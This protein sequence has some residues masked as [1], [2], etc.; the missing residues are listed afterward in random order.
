MEEEK[1]AMRFKALSL[2]GLVLSLLI[3]YLLLFEIPSGKKKGEEEIRSKKVLLFKEEDVKGFEIRS[4]IYDLTVVRDASMGWKITEPIRT[5]PDPG[6]INRFIALLENMEVK[7][8]VEESP[9]DLKIFGL[10]RPDMYI[11]LMLKDREERIMLG[12]RGP[13]KNTLYIKKG[14]DDKIFLA[15]DRLREEIPDKF[16]TWRRALVLPFDMSGVD[17]IR[18]E[19]RDRSFIINKNN[20]KWTL[21]RPIET[22]ADQGEVNDLLSSLSRLS[23]HKFIDDGKEDL[24][25]KI[26]PP[27]LKAGLKIKGEEKGISFYPPPGKEKGIIYAATVNEDPIYMIDEILFKGVDKDLFRLREKQA[28]DLK[29]KSVAGIEIRKDNELIKLIKAKDDWIIDGMPD[30]KIKE[31]KI[32]DLF[33]SLKDIRAERFVDDNPVDLS[34]YGLNKPR[35]E[36]NLFDNENK[37]IGGLLLGKEKRDMI[38]AKNDKS[39]SIFMVKKEV[40]GF[41]PD[42]RDLIGK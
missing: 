9:S 28:L 25:K 42:R 4:D 24:I 21:K 31:S 40:L 26:S 3:L 17:E 39:R 34:R 19:Y 12:D 37:P 2:F 23:T 20:D 8:V 33:D 1:E 15:D 10:D 38:Y 27:I 18:L 6:R 16:S 22:V 30:H 36:I 32:T 29:E 5:D 7:R 13:I 14:G 41:I 35:S 11:L